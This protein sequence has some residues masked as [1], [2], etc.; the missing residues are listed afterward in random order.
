MAGKDAEGNR[1]QVTA[2]QSFSPGVK[3]RTHAPLVW[4]GVSPFDEH[5]QEATFAR[6]RVNFRGRPGPTLMHGRYDWSHSIGPYRRPL[7]ST[8]ART[9]LGVRNPY[10]PPRHYLRG[11][12]V[13]ENESLIAQI[14]R[15]LRQ[16][17]F[18]DAERV[19]VEPIG[20]AD[21]V[22][23]HVPPAGKPTSVSRRSPSSRSH[24]RSRA[25]G[26]SGASRSFE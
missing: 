16:R 26:R 2:T 12:K 24:S 5:E 4:R 21:W 25:G 18:D 6:R 14:R 7:A 13:R 19:I 9:L 23:V 11:G 17:G 10:V 1:L 8:G 3:R 22:A 15:E 20:E